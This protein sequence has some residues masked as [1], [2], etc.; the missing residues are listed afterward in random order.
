MKA[1]S[2]SVADEKAFVDAHISGSSIDVT[3]YIIVAFG[4]SINSAAAVLDEYLREFIPIITG[5]EAGNIKVVITGI[6]AKKLT[7][8]RIEV[9]TRGE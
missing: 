8:R 2:M 7:K 4:H 5:I 9:L 1:V 3:V 6:Q